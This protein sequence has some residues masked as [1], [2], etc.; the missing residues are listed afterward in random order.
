MDLRTMFQEDANA[1][2]FTRGQ[3]IFQEGDQAEYMYVVIEGQVDIVYDD[4]VLETVEPGG[5]LGELA[6]IDQSTRSAQ[7]V[8]KTD[9]KLA[10]IDQRRFTYLV[11]EHPFFAV[12]I[13]SVM[14]N[15][16]RRQTV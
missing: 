4:H 3:T 9:C 1:E 6:L 12:H 10:G 2:S 5:V 15:R 16:L 7:A 13:M 8:A 14:A 11:R